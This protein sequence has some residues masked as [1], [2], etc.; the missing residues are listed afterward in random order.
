MQYTDCCRT[1]D[2]SIDR[3][4]YITIFD[5][6]IIFMLDELEQKDYFVIFRSG[7]EQPIKNE[8]QQGNCPD[9]ISTEII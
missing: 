9:E 4:E 3:N 6:Y 1:R 5:F 2:S 7:L 8:K